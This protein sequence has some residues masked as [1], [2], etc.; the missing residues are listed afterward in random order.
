MESQVSLDSEIEVQRALNHEFSDCPNYKTYSKCNCGPIFKELY[1]YDLTTRVT[2][3]LESKTTLLQCKRDEQCVPGL[4]VNEMQLNTF[5]DSS[6]FEMYSKHPMTSS[7]KLSINSRCLP[8]HNY[9]VTECEHKKGLY[10]NLGMCQCNDIIIENGYCN[11]NIGVAAKEPVADCP[12]TNGK[13]QLAIFN[14]F[15]VCGRFE[16]RCSFG[17]YCHTG[18]QKCSSNQISD[19]VLGDCVKNGRTLTNSL[20]EL[21]KCSDQ[22]YCDGQEYCLIDGTCSKVMQTPCPNED[23]SSYYTGTFE[24]PVCVCKGDKGTKKVANLQ[25]CDVDLPLDFFAGGSIYPSCNTGSN[26]KQILA[27]SGDSRRCTCGVKPNGVYDYCKLGQFCVNERCKNNPEICPN[28]DGTLVNS[29]GN[30]NKC[31]CGSIHAQNNRF[32]NAEM[33]LVASHPIP[34]CEKTLFGQPEICACGSTICQ[35]NDYCNFDESHCANVPNQVCEKTQGQYANEVS[36]LCGTSLCNSPGQYCQQSLNLCSSQALCTNTVG[37][38][39]NTQACQCG[40]ASCG[41]DE[42]CNL[43]QNMCS[44]TPNAQCVVSSDLLEKSCFCS[45][46]NALCPAGKVCHRDGCLD[47]AAECDGTQVC[48]CDGTKCK[49]G[50]FC[51]ADN[52]CTQYDTTAELTYKVVDERTCEDFRYY[53]VEGA[54]ACEAAVQ[55]YYNVSVSVTRYKSQ[56]LAHS[57][58]IRT[59]WNA[60]WRYWTERIRYPKGCAYIESQGYANS[61]SLLDGK[62]SCPKHWSH[63]YGDCYDYSYLQPDGECTRLNPATEC[64]ESHSSCSLLQKCLCALPICKD[65]DV[66]I[67]EYRCG[68]G[69]NVCDSEK[70]LYCYTLDENKPNKCHSVRKCTKNAQTSDACFCSKNNKCEPGEY[71]KQDG[72]CSSQPQCLLNEQNTVSCSCGNNECKSGEFCIEG[73]CSSTNQLPGNCNHGES[74]CVCNQRICG[75]EQICDTTTTTC[76]NIQ[77]IDGTDYIPSGTILNDTEYCVSQR[78]AGYENDI[79]DCE[80]SADDICKCGDYKKYADE[81]CLNDKIYKSI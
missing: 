29:I 4:Y 40:T 79:A 26:F 45:T 10:M 55:G 58:Y 56:N 36:C 54:A 57:E 44:P 48:N 38:E 80:V 41:V 28:T 30:G 39:P 65:E 49:A 9:E 50:E 16:S 21:C 20:T 74:N 43:D 75:S 53:T 23:G 64:P 3:L 37:D 42:Y 17:E 11:V 47:T 70:G 46:T 72:I 63:G 5:G 78:Y 14:E 31:L 8:T 59:W 61:N 13:T 25:Y 33:N 51:S 60:G 69:D 7:D 22:H 12:E 1:E 76:I 32:C 6:K 19:G 34:S 66:N 77:N 24:A 2:K 67:H 71:C 15:C 68:C 18:F 62:A 35:T 81:L 27:I 52:R 73:I